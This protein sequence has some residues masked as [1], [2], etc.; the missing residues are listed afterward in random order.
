VASVYDPLVCDDG[1][2]AA[3]YD[4]QLANEPFVVE[5]EG[6][7]CVPDSQ[8]IVREVERE[9]DA[10]RSDIYTPL[11]IFIFTA[12]LVMIAMHLR[13]RSRIAERRPE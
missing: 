3:E 13:L 10:Q 8:W 5:I 2:V 12:Q 7:L 1:Y 9:L 11:L 4:L 6:T